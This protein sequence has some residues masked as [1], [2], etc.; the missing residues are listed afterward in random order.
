MYQPKTAII[1]KE[2]MTTN[3]RFIIISI[4]LT[5]GLYSC[6]T[7]P[8]KEET[9]IAIISWGGISAEKAD[10]VQEK[11][12]ISMDAA[13]RAGVTRIT[14]DGSARYDGQPIHLEPG[15]LAIFKL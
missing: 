4:I 15:H 2:H 12:L 9:R 14:L 1:A 6:G 5:L 7:E 13:E 3:M 8:V 11:A 10:T